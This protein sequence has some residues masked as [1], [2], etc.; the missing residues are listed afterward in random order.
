MSA[1]AA[2]LGAERA[3]TMP[4]SDFEAA[5][6]LSRAQFDWVL[7]NIQGKLGRKRTR[8]AQLALS[9]TT[10]LLIFLEHL[11]SGAWRERAALRARARRLSASPRSRSA[12]A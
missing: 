10:Q 2:L 11:A 6:G 7:T 3:A 1:E 12:Q 8:A 9:P 4:D 5:F